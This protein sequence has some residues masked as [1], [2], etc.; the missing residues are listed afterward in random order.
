M[1]EFIEFLSKSAYNDLVKSNAELIKMAKNVEVI[2]TTFKSVKVPTDSDKAVKQLN[3]DLA[4]QTK[5]IEQLQKQLL[6]LSNAKQKNNVKTSEEIVGQGILRRNS[7]LHAKSVMALSGAYGRL[8]A[9]VS[10]ASTRYQDI[11]V[12]GRLATQSQSQYNRELRNAQREFTVLQA[13]VLQADKA[14]GKWN[15][16]GER[17]IGFAKNLMGAFG[18]VGGVSL[19][20]MISRDI[21]QTI[22]ETESL[23]KALKQVTGTQENFATQ[24]AFLSETSQAFGLEINGLTKQFTQFYVSAKD[25]ISG[26]EIQDIF[27]SVSKAGAVMGLSVETQQRA[28]LA[29][30][31]MMSKGT[32]QAEEL[33]GQL[34][35]ALPGA[36]G[37]MAKAVGVTEK[38]LAKMMKSGDLLA[39][40]VL[41][42]FAAQLEKT[43]GIE[44]VTKVE[45]LTAAQNRLS[46]SWTNF[47]KSL[48]DDGNKLSKFFGSLL[49]EATSTLEAWQ[50]IFS[51]V[52][53]IRKN[54]ANSFTAGAENLAKRNLES[55]STL[56]GKEKFAR[57][58]VISLEKEKAQ[59]NKSILDL[60]EKNINITKT[61]VRK[62]PLGDILGTSSRNKIKENEKAIEAYNLQVAKSQGLINGYKSILKEEVVVK[63]VVIKSNKDLNE[64]ITKQNEILKI[65]SEKWIKGQI[66]QLKDLQE[67]NDTTTESYKLS[68]KTIEFYEQWLERLQGTTKDTTKEIENLGLSLDLTDDVAM[69]EGAFAYIEKNFDDFYKSFQDKIVGQSG[70]ES[71]FEILN[72]GLEN[73]G[74][75]WKAKAL[76]I[77]EAT[78]E[79]FNFISNLSQKNFEA[80]YAR[81][82]D[83][84]RVAKSFSNQSAE[85]I[86]EIEERSEQKRKEIAN[87]EN[88]AKK[89][90]AIFNI[91]IDTAQAVMAVIA[92]GG[93]LWEGIVVGA[94]GLAQ[95]A[96]VASQEIP[97]YW[98]GGTHDGGMMMVNDDPLGIKGNNYRE[99]IQTPDGKLSSPKGKNVKMNK[100]QG[101]K[102]FTQDQFFS[103]F[104]GIMANAGISSNQTQNIN[105]DNSILAH[106]LDALIALGNSKGNIDIVLDKLGMNVYEK[107]QG[108]RETNF[109]NRKQIKGKYV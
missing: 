63:K 40:D 65:G 23:D 59:I 102:I 35:E 53:T 56:E 38:E 22:K 73:Y 94:L 74:D 26:G 90:Q 43:Y 11:I 19:F 97:Q 2:N 36:F 48:D 4:K 101:T 99:I 93:K 81:N 44:T 3:E 30:N 92:R 84:A 107:S 37:I 95:I 58:Q 72:G 86:A 71:L 98:Q 54:E 105:L 18:I 49:D 42:R 15:R 57:E 64:S 103:G 27:R 5:L 7:D 89:K 13:K 52:E 16:T 50:K 88:Q 83:K 29:L 104:N 10:K 25:K 77:M 75:N 21:F 60:K 82:E 55:F 39:S 109:N 20:A 34:G 106:K 28:F 47:V 46:N 61:E 70:F 78:Q 24:Q 1:A 12:R 67:T 68:S 9:D 69:T 33:R 6:N 62:T 41:P 14:V 85:A 32:I 108:K 17:S 51:S 31:Q 100:P 45:T 76:V 96:T 91:A 79:M 8:S 66:S 87:R 80:E